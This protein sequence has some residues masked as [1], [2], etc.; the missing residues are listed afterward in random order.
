MLYLNKLFKFQNGK[1]VQKGVY[2][3]GAIQIEHAVFWFM[4]STNVC[5]VL[6]FFLFY[7]LGKYNF[8]NQTY[9]KICICQCILLLLLELSL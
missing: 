7:Q 4:S 3:R 9:I 8:P 2:E 6:L 1:T 5:G